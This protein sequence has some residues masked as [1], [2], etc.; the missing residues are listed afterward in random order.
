MEKFGNSQSGPLVLL[1]SLNLHQKVILAA[2][3]GFPHTEKMKILT[4]QKLYDEYCAGGR[5]CMPKLYDPVT[6]SEFIDLIS[7]LESMSIIGKS[8]SNESDVWQLKIYL[9]IPDEL[10]KTLISLELP[11]IKALFGI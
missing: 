1:K 4:I 7:N 3:L 5:N 9:L 8:S 6:R 11:T 10:V 2:I